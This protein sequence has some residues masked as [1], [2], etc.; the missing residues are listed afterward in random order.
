[1]FVSVHLFFPHVL[2]LWMCCKSCWVMHLRVVV[3]NWP[4]M[5]RV[6]VDLEHGLGKARCLPRES[7]IKG[8][9]KWP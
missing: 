1:M 2:K 8:V 7:L 3:D 6:F 4:L 9:L 5:T